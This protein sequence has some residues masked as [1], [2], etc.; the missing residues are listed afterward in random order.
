MKFYNLFF[1]LSEA[2]LCNISIDIQRVLRIRG[3]HEEEKILKE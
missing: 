1:Y 2:E 3:D